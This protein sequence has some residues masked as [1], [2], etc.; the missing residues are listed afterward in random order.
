[1]LYII[2]LLILVIAYM[3]SVSNIII[4][5]DNNTFNFEVSIISINIV[6]VTF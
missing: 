1:M 4:M 6:F 3:G 2:I 5:F